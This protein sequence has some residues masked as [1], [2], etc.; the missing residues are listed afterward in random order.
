[1]I[2]IWPRPTKAVFRFSRWKI[3]KLYCTCALPNYHSVIFPLI[4][5]RY[6]LGPF[7]PSF[8]P[9]N[10]SHY[11]ARFLTSLLSTPDDIA[12]YLTTELIHWSCQIATAAVAFSNDFDA[13][14]V[15]NG[16][17][18]GGEPRSHVEHSRVYYQRY[19]GDLRVLGTATILN[20]NLGNIIPNRL[21]LNKQMNAQGGND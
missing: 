1:M 17:R 10:T 4:I 19:I 5:A 2:C 6:F 7:L 16:R 14:S 8:Q 3:L 21:D 9:T 13:I 15:P 20:F 18:G 12:L 11:G